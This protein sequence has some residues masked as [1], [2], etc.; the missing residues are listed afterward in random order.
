[1]THCASLQ[2]LDIGAIL[3]TEQIDVRHLLLA[4]SPLA[5][6][7]GARTRL[8]TEFNFFSLFFTENLQLTTKN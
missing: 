6:F 3:G 7:P 2:E 4:D 8:Q 1:M 5:P